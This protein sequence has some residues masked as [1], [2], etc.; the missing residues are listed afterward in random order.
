MQNK[1][2][3]CY[4]DVLGVDRKVPG[5]EL[6]TAFRKLALVLHPDKNKEEDTTV[7]FQELNEAYSVLNDPHERQ[8]YDDH[9][10][11]ILRGKEE[12]G[13]EDSVGYMT[14]MNL[15]PFFSASAYSGYN[16]EEGGFYKVYNNLFVQLDKEEELEE[17]VGVEHNYAPRFGDSMSYNDEILKFY[18]YWSDFVTMKEFSYADAYNPNVAPNRR[19]K[20][21]IDKENKKERLKEKKKFNDLVKEIVSFVKK[22]DPRYQKYIKKKTE[23]DEIKLKEKQERTER[24]KKEKQELLKQYKEEMAKKYAEE[25]EELKKHKTTEDEIFHNEKKEEDDDEEEFY[26]KVC[27][28][29]FKSKGQLEN[30][31]NSKKHKVAV[32][33]LMKKLRIDDDDEPENDKVPEA[34]MIKTSKNEKEAEIEVNEKEE[35]IITSIS[36]KKQKKKDKKKEIYSKNLNEDTEEQVQ[37]DPTNT[38]TKANDGA[39][40][41]ENVQ[42]LQKDINEEE[43]KD[44]EKS[45]GK[46]EELSEE[47]KSSVKNTE[48][49]KLSKKQKRKEKEKEKEIKKTEEERAELKCHKCNKEFDTRNKLFQHVNLTGHAQLK[50]VEETKKAKKKK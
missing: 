7:K 8:W 10:D 25:Y 23:E 5:D 1:A 32:E 26:C 45:E 15:W 24:E 13:D 29:D 50:Q 22:R 38:K 37:E 18:E 12:P 17:M 30:H 49:V 44:N 28:K 42:E 35:V 19:V 2:K 46:S 43:L 48:G 11:Q 47:A 36:K 21:I 4:Y 31:N 6:K 9:R 39:Q 41:E 14:K 34:D 16:D 40:I 3:R 27:S 33:K 20:R